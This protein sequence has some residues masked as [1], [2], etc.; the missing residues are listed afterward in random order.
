MALYRWPVPMVEVT[1]QSPEN[2][3]ESPVRL[4]GATR[5]AGFLLP[6]APLDLRG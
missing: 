1:R 2:G 4:R 3:Q 6:A 5:R